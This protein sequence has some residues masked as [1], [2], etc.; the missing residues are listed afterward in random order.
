MALQEV[1]DSKTC[2]SKDLSQSPGL[3]APLN[4][5]GT[6]WCYAFSA[7]DLVSFKIKKRISAFDVATQFHESIRS[8]LV[9]RFTHNKTMHMLESGGNIEEALEAAS[10]R[11]MCS[12]AELPSDYNNN[13]MYDY[14]SQVESLKAANSP[15]A[16][17]E[18]VKKLFPS[19]LADEVKNILSAYKGEERTMQLALAS[20]K[21][22]IQVPKIRYQSFKVKDDPS[23]KDLDKQLDAGNILAF[24]H[25]PRFFILGPDYTPK[26]IDYTHIATVVGR[27]FINGQ[28]MYK[29]KG[30]SG[31]NKNYK[32]ASPYKENNSGGYV[33]VDKKTLA[34]FSEKFT[35]VE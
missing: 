7:A 2:S 8:S 4:R 22:K 15:S 6:G 16:T 18:G 1:D 32:Y 11:P 5:D 34:K 19:L 31:R 30:S 29:I 21:N 28:C 10:G 26:K 13:S 33:W 3:E 25:D 27:K 23:L 24:D 9:K 14:V 20:C 12:E 35:Y 17:C